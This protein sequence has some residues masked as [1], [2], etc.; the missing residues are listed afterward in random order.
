MRGVLTGGAETF[1]VSEISEA[2]K[3]LGLAALGGMGLAAREVDTVPA[4]LAPAP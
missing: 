2:K 4:I 3:A 1:G